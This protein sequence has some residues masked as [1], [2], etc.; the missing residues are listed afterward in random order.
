MLSMMKETVRTHV[1]VPRDLIEAID[2]VAGKR[3]RSEFV[4]EALREKLTRERQKEALAA[5]A[6]VLKDADYPEWE[7]PEQTSQWVHDLRCVADAHTSEKLRGS[8]RV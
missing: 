7:T 6:G 8:A 2:R 5:T 3:K 4:T 1:H